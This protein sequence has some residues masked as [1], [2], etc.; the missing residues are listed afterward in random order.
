MINSNDFDTGVF[1]LPQDKFGDFNSFIT[2]DEQ[3]R[4]LYEILG[5]DFAND[6]WDKQNDP[7]YAKLIDGFDELRGLKFYLKC[8]TFYDFVT[9]LTTFQTK[10]GENS[11]EV[12][13]EGITYPINAVKLYNQGVEEARKIRC[14][15]RN[16]HDDYD[17]EMKGCQPYY[18]SLI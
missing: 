7:E 11:L 4:A 18:Q 14:Y 3:K 5:F 16:H 8:K 1:K 2:E 13:G 9:Y 12:A 15:I 10:S 17:V 6:L